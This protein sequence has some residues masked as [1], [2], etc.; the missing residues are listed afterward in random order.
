[1]CFVFLESKK[2]K[3]HFTKLIKNIFC[4]YSMEK[5][6]LE[7]YIPEVTIIDPSI[8]KDYPPLSDHGFNQP[9]GNIQT[10]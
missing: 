6:K 1:M 9:L 8:I 4:S 2:G 3:T 7:R 10:F 5:P